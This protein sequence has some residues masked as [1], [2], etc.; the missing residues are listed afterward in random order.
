MTEAQTIEFAIAFQPVVDAANNAVWAQEAIPVGSSGRNLEALFVE[1]GTEGQL[2]LDSSIRR[3]TLEI[4]GKSTYSGKLILNVLPVAM[5]SGP[6]FIAQL[7]EDAQKA[8]IPTDRI[9]LRI[10]ENEII[11]D[12]ESFF[13]AVEELRFH[14]INFAIGEFGS[15][16]AGLN[17]L[18]DF[19]PD[20][21]KLDRALVSGIRARGPRQAIVRGVARTCFDLGIDVVVEGVETADEYGWFRDEGIDLF[22]GPLIAKPGFDSFAGDFSLPDGPKCHARQGMRS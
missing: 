15:G 12:V 7:L 20:L 19:Q 1:V 8:D 17:L 16:F 6:Q 4:A 2:A 5:E 22:Q 10:S 9:F 18:A 14:G 3:R 13:A 21:V 11:V